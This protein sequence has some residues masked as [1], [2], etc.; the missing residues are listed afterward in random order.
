MITVADVTAEALGAFLVADFRRN[1]GCAE[2]RYA[3]LIGSTAR[4]ALEC[5]ANSDALYHN[6]EHTMLVVLAGRDIL[7]GRALRERVGACD[8]AHFLVACLLHDIGYVRGLLMQDTQTA[9]VIDHRGNTASLPRGASDAGL[10]PYHVDRAKLFVEAR[11]H[12]SELIDVPRLNRMIE[13]TRFPYPKEA[14]D[15]QLDEETGLVRA[16][17]L[18][19]QLGDPRYLRKTN[20]LFHEFQEIG[21]AETLGYTTP[22]DLVDHYPAF[23]WQHV[24]AQITPALRHLDVT[25]DGRRWIAHLQANI[26]AAE[27][28]PS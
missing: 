5:I 13:F 18:V 6:L 3:E 8:W 15:T 25:V 11:F 1:C 21:M 20:A 2:E 28:R 12:D 9:F 16:A 27:L 14:V 23:F 10:T 26:F 24:A 7:R 4:L 17:D 19:G 22:A